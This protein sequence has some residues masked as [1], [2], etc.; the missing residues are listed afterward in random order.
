[1]LG[2]NGK[3]NGK[4]HSIKGLG[5]RV[6]RVR[7]LCKYVNSGDSWVIIWLVG[8][9]NIHMLTESPAPPPQPKVLLSHM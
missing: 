9:R 4:C 2:I 6:L 8:A 3:D 7:G 5:F 1:M